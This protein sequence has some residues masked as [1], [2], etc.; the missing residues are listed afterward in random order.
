MT[1]R[2]TLP[3]IVLM[4]GALVITYTW[5][6]SS[7]NRELIAP[8]KRIA[9]S[10]F[11]LTDAAG[12]EVSLSDYKDKVVLLNFWATWCGPCEV[13]IPWFKEFE[14]TYKDKGFAVLG[15]SEDEGGW[16]TVRAYIEARK[17]NYRVLLDT[18]SEKM[19][20]PYKEIAGLPTTY[21]IDR[22][23]RV[24]ITHTGLVSKSTYE[25]GIQQLLQQ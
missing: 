17:M 4:A 9:A 23:G 2:N 6:P 1:L 25:S 24:A 12:K 22:Q 13:E 14:Q 7:G 5:A 3:W 15:V 11:K 18:D 20:S 21:L 19:P 16:P 8:E 10:D